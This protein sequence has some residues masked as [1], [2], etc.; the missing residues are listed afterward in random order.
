M[1]VNNPVASKTEEGD[2]IIPLQ[3]VWSGAY[4]AINVPGAIAN[5]GQMDSFNVL[6]VQK[7][8]VIPRIK[9]IFGT[10]DFGGSNAAQAKGELYI[11]FPD[12]GELFAL[13]TN[14]IY[15]IAS[16]VV[17]FSFSVLAKSPTNIQ[18][19][20]IVDGTIVGMSGSASIILTTKDCAPF[21]GGM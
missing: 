6:S 4:G 18:F 3:L 21:L 1:I 15:A 8:Q 7:N 17:T 12:T 2:F 14:A 13:K 5:Q 19:F 10:V 20:K 11:F 9:S 16:G